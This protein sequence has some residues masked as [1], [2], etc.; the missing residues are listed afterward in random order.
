MRIIEVNNSEKAKAFLAINVSLNKNNPYYIQPLDS[1]IEAVFDAQKNKHFK[2][3]KI[4]RWI[5]QDDNNHTIGR[6]AAFTYSKYKNYGTDFPVGGV[7]FFDCVDNQEA[8]NILFETAKNWLKEQGMDAMDG[9]INFGDRDKWWGLMVEGFD[10]EPYYGMSFN[11]SYYHKL[12][13]N[14]GF[15][16]YYNQYYFYMGI[17]YQ[18]PERFK[19]RHDRFEN[20]KEYSAKHLDINQLEKFATDFSIVYNAAWAQHNENKTITSSDVMK[21][22]KQLKPIIDPKIIWFAYFKDE[23]IAM[24]I[25]IPDINQ[26]FKHFKGKLGIWQ[27]IRLLYLKKTK[28]CHRFTGIAFGVVP[29]YQALGVDSF[30]IYEGAKLIQSES[31]YK[32][33]EM[34]W[35]SEWNPKMLNIYQSL[36]SYKSRTMVTYRYIFDGKHPFEKHPEIQYTK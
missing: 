13:E 33:Y 5:L 18:L 6:I 28:K 34:G 4:I 17:E 7:G 11:P 14:Y 16:N 2:Y 19:E 22:F 15:Q 8:A 12:F 30:M 32:H 35:T 1:E 24:W 20:K 25:N 10:N 29:K 21:L 9:P 3:G 31:Q 23:P 27:K 26:Y 36:G